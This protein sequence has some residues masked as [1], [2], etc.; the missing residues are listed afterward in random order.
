MYHQFPWP[1]KLIVSVFCRAKCWEREVDLCGSSLQTSQRPFW[2]CHCQSM[3][4]G[5][6]A[7]T[8][9]RG[10]GSGH[11]LWNSGALARRLGD[12]LKGCH[13]HSGMGWFELESVFPHLAHHQNQYRTSWVWVLST[14][15]LNQYVWGKVQLG[16]LC[17]L[18]GW[19]RKLNSHF[20]LGTTVLSDLWPSFL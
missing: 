14:Q 9:G 7:D 5:C 17:F 8:E 12:P 18:N 2:G 10:Q 20:G 11:L 6:F 13:P 16:D 19:P 4:L 1:S 15:I 3:G